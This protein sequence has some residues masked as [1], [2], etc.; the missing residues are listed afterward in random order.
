MRVR[1]ESHR[2][3]ISF[4]RS[5]RTKRALGSRLDAI[6]GVGPARKRQLLK[7]IGSLKKIGDATVAELME[8]DGIGAELAEQIHDY[9]QNPSPTR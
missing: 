1:D 9:F 2:F 6:P 3:G 7:Q 5:L 8:V 4:H